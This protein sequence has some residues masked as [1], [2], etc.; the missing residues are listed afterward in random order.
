MKLQIDVCQM[1][2]GTPESKFVVVLVDF[3]SIWL[4]KLDSGKAL[5]L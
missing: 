2:G 3:G 5:N 4:S 1:F